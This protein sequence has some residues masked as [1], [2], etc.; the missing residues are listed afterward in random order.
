MSRAR[1]WVVAAT[2]RR[3]KALGGGGGGGGVAIAFQTEWRNATGFTEAAFRDGTRFDA[4][5]GALDGVPGQI[6]APDASLATRGNYF[7]ITAAGPASITVTKADM[8]ARSTTYWMRAYI[9]SDL[10]TPPYVF[11]HAI[12]FGGIGVPINMAVGFSIADIFGVDINSMFFKTLYDDTGAAVSYPNIQWQ[13]QDLGDGR[14][15]NFATGTWW[16]FEWQIEY[17][18]ATTYWIRS[19]MSSVDSNGDIVTEDVYTNEHFMRQDA[20]GVVGDTLLTR[21]GSTIDFGLSTTDGPEAGAKLVVGNESSG[22]AATSEHT[23][24]ASLA[25]STQGRIRDQVLVF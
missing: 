20:T 24:I 14:P 2:K 13:P 4:Y 17:L 18:T 11:N 8:V 23:F 15:V 3:A 10:A 12:A 6:V 16:L 19:Y 9:R 21:Q 7:R 5:N 25:F 22:A 1:R